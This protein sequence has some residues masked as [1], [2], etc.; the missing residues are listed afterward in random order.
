M[1]D[2]PS[3]AAVPLAIDAVVS[4]LSELDTVFGPQARPT[5]EA[6]RASLLE[7]MAA[8]DRGDGA[9]AVARI[10]EAMDR[11]ASLADGLEEAE[12]MLMRVLAEQFRSA[13]LRRDTAG[14]RRTADVMFERSGARWVEPDAP[15]KKS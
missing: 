1:A 14:A 12:A 15:R 7:A 10:G 5:L 11:L 13:L 9:A 2:D 4:R 8:R 3:P 6:V